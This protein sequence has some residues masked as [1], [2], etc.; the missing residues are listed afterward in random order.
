MIALAW[1]PIAL[2]FGNYGIA[3]LQQQEASAKLAVQTEVQTALVAIG[4]LAK[5][6]LPTNGLFANIAKGQIDNEIDSYVANLNA[7]MPAFL[8]T[9]WDALVAKL[10]AI[11]TAVTTAPAAP[12]QPGA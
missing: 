11:V 8:D 5:N 1:R 2:A 9:A 12:P 7:A 6:A 4:T 10:T 3:L